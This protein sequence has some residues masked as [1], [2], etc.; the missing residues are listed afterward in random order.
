MGFPCVKIQNEGISLCCRWLE[1]ALRGLTTSH[2]P[3]FPS[4]LNSLDFCFMFCQFTSKM[5]RSWHHIKNVYSSKPV[6][7]GSGSSLSPASILSRALGGALSHS[8]MAFQSSAW[9]LGWTVISRQ[10]PTES[11]W[12]T[13]WVLIASCVRMYQQVN[14]PTYIVLTALSKWRL[15]GTHPSFPNTKMALPQSAP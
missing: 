11:V 10:T 1:L 5:V 13:P 9:P 4:I 3:W 14:V 8:S 12:L 15:N 7:Q 2:S 6:W